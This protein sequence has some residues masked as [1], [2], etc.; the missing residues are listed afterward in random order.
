M[1]L[2]AHHQT[3]ASV[4]D[5]IEPLPDSLVLTPISRS[6]T[7]L[8]E[9]TVQAVLARPAVGTRPRF[10]SDPVL[11]RGAKRVS[12][13]I[14]TFNGLVFT[15]LCLESVLSNT[16]YPNYEIIVLD[17]GSD[18]G[19][20]DYLREL[21]RQQQCLRVVFHGRNLGFA[22]ANNHGLRL[23]TGDVFVLLNNDTLV[24]PGWLSRLLRRLEDPAIGLVGPVTNRAGNEAQI[25]VPYSTYGEFLQFADGHSQAHHGKHFDIR[26]LAMFCVAL[27]RDLYERVGSLDERFGLGLFEDDDYAMRV[28]KGGYRVV[29]AEDAFVH[30]FGQA[31]LGWLAGAGKYGELFHANRRLWEEKWQTTWHPYGRR[32]TAGYVALVERIRAAVDRAVPVAATV[33]VVSKGDD[34]LLNLHGRPAWHFPQASDG[35]YAGHHLADSAEAIAQL[36]VLRDRGGSFLLIPS[37]A[38][39]WLD[40]YGEFRR[41]LEGRYRQVLRQEDACVIFALG[42]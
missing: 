21:E 23:A 15:K 2:A 6:P 22:A 18:D 36:E 32:A 19:T 11:C 10:P 17:N 35:G 39:W 24:P 4:C 29:C 26:M 7:R 5:A 41:H 12:I 9:T 30:H 37:T 33:I 40:Y 20:A 31:S 34:E 8:S 42:V 14:V 3:K 38:M 1:A 27:R 13:V 16:D 28:R 25:E